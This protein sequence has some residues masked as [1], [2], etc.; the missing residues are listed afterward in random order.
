MRFGLR[1]GRS[2]GT[3]SPHKCGG[4]SRGVLTDSPGEHQGVQPAESGGVSPD[5]LLRLV[6][7]QF[8][9]LGRP[10]I[11][12]LPR[13]EIATSGLVSETPSRPDSWFTRLSNWSAV[14]PSAARGIGPGPDRDR[15]CACP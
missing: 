13:Q 8:D 9:R 14:I 1:P 5:P 11:D 3:P 6:T 7:E 15:P 2:R 4:G 12:I 10:D